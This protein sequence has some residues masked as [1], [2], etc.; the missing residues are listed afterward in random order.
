M[1]ATIVV[2]VRLFAAIA[3]AAGTRELT[4]TLPAGSRLGEAIAELA[5]A[6]PAVAPWTQRVALARNHVYADPGEP[7]ADG[8]EIA[9]IPPV[10]GGEGGGEAV[11]AQGTRAGEQAPLAEADHGRFLI[12]EAPLD[13]SRVAA[14]AGHRRAGAISLFCGT[15]REFTGERR[16]LRLEY[17]AY[18]EMAVKEMQRLAAEIRERWPGTRV[19]MH[20]RVGRLGIGEISVVVA[21]AA[22]HR[23]EAFTA[24]RFAIDELK[25]RIPIW[26]KEVYEDGSEWVGRDGTTPPTPADKERR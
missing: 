1:A 17:D 9:L 23:S 6:V 25:R 7:L 5:R 26:K 15:V 16:T 20:H 19:A 3:E 4:L 8:D 10:S 11:S 22:P 18:A 2:R 12:T 14:L 24:C 13:P 21:V